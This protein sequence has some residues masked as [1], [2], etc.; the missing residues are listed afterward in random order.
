MVAGKSKFAALD[1]PGTISH[2]FIPSAANSSVDNETVSVR[3]EQMIS[4]FKPNLLF[5]HFADVDAAGHD[6]GWGLAR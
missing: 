4:A 3:A 5:V 2:V 1:K 6:H